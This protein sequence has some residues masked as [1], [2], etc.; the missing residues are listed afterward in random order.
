MRCVDTDF[1]SKTFDKVSCPI[2]LFKLSTLR[3][4]ELILQ[5]FGIYLIGVPSRLKSETTF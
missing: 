1:S 5:W 4:S 3:S 2:L